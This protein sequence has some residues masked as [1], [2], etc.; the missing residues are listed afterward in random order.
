MM[1]A[2]IRCGRPTPLPPIRAIAA[3]KQAVLHEGLA[4]WTS[5]P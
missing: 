4:G 2:A 5:R 3:A 1:V